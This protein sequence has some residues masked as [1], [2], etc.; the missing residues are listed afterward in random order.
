MSYVYTNYATK[1]QF[2]AAVNTG[3]RHR[4]YNPSGMYEPTQNGSDVIEGPHYPAP[5]KWYASVEVK[6]G[7]VIKAK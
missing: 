5:H 1:K 4:T 2:V 7:V 6:D 3:V